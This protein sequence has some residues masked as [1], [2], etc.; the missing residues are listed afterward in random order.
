MTCSH[1]IDTLNSQLSTLNSQLSISNSQISNS[2]TQTPKLELN[3]QNKRQECMHTTTLLNSRSIST[4]EHAMSMYNIYNCDTTAAAAAAAAT[5]IIPLP[6]SNYQVIV[7][8]IAGY[9][10]TSAADTRKYQ[11]TPRPPAREGC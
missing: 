7:A 2:Q 9:R 10:E 8:G 4:N 3:T 6:L 5:A 11:S 1:D